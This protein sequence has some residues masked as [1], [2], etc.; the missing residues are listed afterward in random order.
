MESPKYS[1]NWDDALKILEVIWWHV[2][3]ALVTAFIAVLG[4]LDLGAYA[5]LLPA[6]NAL[7]YGAKRFV[8]GKRG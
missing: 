4:D 2:A 7:L 3:S 6:V 5:V 8:D 1:L